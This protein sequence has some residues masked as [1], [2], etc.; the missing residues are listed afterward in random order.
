MSYFTQTGQWTGY[1]E[2]RGTKGTMVFNNFYINPVPQG[3]VK[4]GGSDSIG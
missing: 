2:Q 1:Y 4:G 3:F